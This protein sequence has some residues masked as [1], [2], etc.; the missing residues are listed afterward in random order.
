M[1][2]RNLHMKNR[3]ISM[4]W[5]VV[6]L[7][8]SLCQQLPSVRRREFWF[9]LTLALAPILVNEEAAF[10]LHVGICTCRSWTCCAT[11]ERCKLG[12]GASLCKTLNAVTS[13]SSAIRSFPFFF[14]GRIFIRKAAVSQST[15]ARN[16]SAIC[17]R[18]TF[19]ATYDDTSYTL[20]ELQ[21]NN[22]DDIYFEYIT[23]YQAM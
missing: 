9:K 5:W 3:L 7:S 14:Y 13:T 1:I 20:F 10:L 16:C 18:M 4:I 17:P 2:L 6:S 8:S 23:L 11:T 21:I 22:V 19:S 15:R 12:R